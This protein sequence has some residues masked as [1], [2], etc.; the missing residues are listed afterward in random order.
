[1][2]IYKQPKFDVYTD[3]NALF[4]IS[5]VFYPPGWR[6]YIDEQ[7]VETVYKT[8]H[9]IQSIIVPSGSHKIEMHFEPESYSRN[10]NLAYISVSI[11]YLTLLGSLISVI[12]KRSKNK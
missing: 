7:K 8:D 3:K 10:I 2:T 6:I 5:D 1:M 12:L 4:V 11:L 9:A